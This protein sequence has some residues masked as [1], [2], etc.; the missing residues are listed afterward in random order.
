MRAASRQVITCDHP[1][2]RREA[3]NMPRSASMTVSVLCGECGE[4]V[5]VTS[6]DGMV[7]AHDSAGSVILAR[8]RADSRDGAVDGSDV[9]VIQLSHRTPLNTESLQGAYG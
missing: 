6:E 8:N 5:L 3:A 2:A 1:D 4:V 7:W 9:V